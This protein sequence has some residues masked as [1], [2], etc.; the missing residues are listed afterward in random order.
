[1]LKIPRVFTSKTCVCPLGSSGK[2]LSNIPSILISYILIITHTTHTTQTTKY[3]ADSP[4]SLKDLDMLSLHSVHSVHTEYDYIIVD[5]KLRG[6]LNELTVTTTDDPLQ[7]P[8]PPL[9]SSTEQESNTEPSSSSGDSATHS[10]QTSSGVSTCPSTT[11][12]PRSNTDSS[13]CTSGTSSSSYLSYGSLY[14]LFPEQS[15]SHNG[16]SGCQTDS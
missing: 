12:F 3:A 4:A 9:Q 16:S 13:T 14:T 11:R 8:K 7:S 1:M 2:C 6:S 5:G 15:R 10:S